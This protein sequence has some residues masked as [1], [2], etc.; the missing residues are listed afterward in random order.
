MVYVKQALR[1]SVEDISKPSQDNNQ[2]GK[3]GKS[4]EEMSVVFVASYKSPE[5]LDPTNRPLHFPATA[6]ATKLAPV[7]CRSVD[8]VRTMGAD[9]LDAA[10]P[11]SRAQRVAVCSGIVNQPER[12][13][14]KNTPFEQRLDKRYFVRT[15]AGCIDTQRD[16]MTI[17]KDHEFGPLA[18]LRFANLF[19]PFFADENVPSANDS[20]RSMRRCRSSLRSNRP[21]AISQMPSSVHCFK[22]RQQVAGDG[23][24]SGRSLQGAPVR[25]IQRIPSTQRRAG[26]RGR[27]P[28]GPTGDSGKR[29]A[30]RFH[31]SS[32][33]RN[34]GSIMDPV[35]D[36]TVRRDRLAMRDLL[37]LSL[38]TARTQQ[39]FS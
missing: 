25:R 27:P 36:S 17:G 22:R 35:D 12:L 34:S 13:S 2:A 3:L 9:Q 29:S 26:T 28:S 24:Q 16:S 32:S 19:A 37:S 15:G 20:S 18:S 30:I 23:K 4:V 33:S 38:I 11:K 8:P 7:L 39:R 6:V 14:S 10:L 21:H 1:G 5:V 31:C